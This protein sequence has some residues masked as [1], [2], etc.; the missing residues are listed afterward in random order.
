MPRP[1][2]DSKYVLSVLKYL[3]ILKFLSYTQKFLGVLK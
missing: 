1:F 2:A 3:G